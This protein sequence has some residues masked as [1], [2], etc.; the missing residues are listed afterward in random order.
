MVR[1]LSLL[2]AGLVVLPS[3][4]LGQEKPKLD[5]AAGQ[6][7][8][9]VGQAENCGES[10]ALLRKICARIASTMPDKDRQSCALPSLSFQART[11][12]PLQ[13]FKQN[14]R[15]EWKR[16]EPMFDEITREGREHWRRSYAD[17]IAERRIS[18]LDVARLSDEVLKRCPRTEAMLQA[19]PRRN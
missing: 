1:T 13:E 8:L 19:K 11:A 18:M 7:I 15:D 10:D 5:A 14:F 6:M 9:I 4:A 16:A 2:L 17:L 3:S 12:R